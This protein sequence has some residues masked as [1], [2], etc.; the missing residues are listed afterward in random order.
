MLLQLI[1][2]HHRTDNLLESRNAGI[3]KPCLH[4]ETYCLRVVSTF[5]FTP[6][7]N[8]PQG[9]DAKPPVSSGDRAWFDSLETAGFPALHG[10]RCRDSASVRLCP[11]LAIVSQQMRVCRVW[12]VRSHVFCKAHAWQ[13]WDLRSPCSASGA[14]GSASRTPVR[15]PTRHRLQARFRIPVTAT[16][17]W[18]FP[19]RLPR[20]SLPVSATPSHRPLRARAGTR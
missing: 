15:I 16:R 3:S 6:R 9:G 8:P 5:Y 11:A 14:A 1:A 12:V 18:P 4:V 7:A 13:R 2:R 20:V 17:H 19:G 10:V